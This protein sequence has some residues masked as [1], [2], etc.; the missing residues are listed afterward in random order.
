MASDRKRKRSVKL[1]GTRTH[2]K[3]NTKNKRGK[4]RKAGKGMAGFMKSKWTY[5]VKYMKD[6]FGVHGFNSISKKLESVSVERIN[7]LAATGRLEKK[8]SMFEFQ[9]KGKV[10]GTGK[11]EFP[12]KVVASRISEGAKE[13]IIAAKG[14]AI[15]TAAEPEEQAAVAFP[16]KE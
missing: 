3:G 15:E 12:V 8:G 10:L 6:Y 16:G 14:E 5:T 4:G 9:F 11:L 7:E 1:H 13:K 2:G